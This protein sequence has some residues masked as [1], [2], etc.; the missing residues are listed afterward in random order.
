MVT[1]GGGET[2][3]K[4]SW[5]TVHSHSVVL[6]Q[7]GESGKSFEYSHS[8]K[9]TT[10]SSSVR[11]QQITAH[12]SRIQ[13]V[14]CLIAVDDSTFTIIGYRENA[15]ETLGLVL[16]GRAG[17][18]HDKARRA[19]WLVSR[20]CSPGELACVMAVLAGRAGPCHSR[21]RRAIRFGCSFSRVLKF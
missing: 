5:T 2:D 20:P 9:A 15:R 7:S 6:E 1:G 10:Y 12:L 16:A 14:G 21:A 18:R 17:P 4:Q 8:V 3:R 11:E 19:S 13:R